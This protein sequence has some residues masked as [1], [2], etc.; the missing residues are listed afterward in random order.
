MTYEWFLENNDIEVL[1][2]F[3]W[4]YEDT[5]TKNIW[6][7]RSV[8]DFKY[9]KTVLSTKQFTWLFIISLVCCLGIGIWV[10]LNNHQCKEDWIK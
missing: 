9:L 1:S 8:N 10:V 4:W 6:E 2:R 3:P 5:L 7:C